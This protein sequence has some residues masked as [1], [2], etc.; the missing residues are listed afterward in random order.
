MFKKKIPNRLEG[1]SQQ[2]PHCDQRVL[3]AP[4][5]CEFCDAHPQWQQ[6]RIDWSICFTGY[7]PEGTELPD[8]ATYARGDTLNKWHGNVAKPLL[9]AIRQL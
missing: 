1:F 9:G 7:E 6:L 2:Y 5:E 3:H 4:G 8:P